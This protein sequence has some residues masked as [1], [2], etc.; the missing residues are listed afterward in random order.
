ML[1]EQPRPDRPAPHR[2]R[3]QHIGGGVVGVLENGLG[4]TAAERLRILEAIKGDL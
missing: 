2:P 1:E 3:L 4:L